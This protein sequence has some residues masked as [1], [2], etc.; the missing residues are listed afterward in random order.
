MPAAVDDLRA[1]PLFAELEPD[2]LEHL[3]GVATAVEAQPDQV[4][5]QPLQAGTGMYFV[6]EGTVEG[7]ARE[8]WRERGAGNFFGEVGVLT[9][10]GRRAG[11][12]RAKTEL[13]CLAFDRAAFE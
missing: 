5:V 1:I 7:E 2:A 10:D 3:A 11:R 9:D 13:R 12:C 6:V 4:L 8:G